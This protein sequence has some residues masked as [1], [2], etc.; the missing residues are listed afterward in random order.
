MFVGLRIGGHR[1]DVWT[2]HGP[3]THLL[4]AAGYLGRRSLVLAKRFPQSFERDIEARARLETRPFSLPVT[5]EVDDRTGGR[6]NQYVHTI[7]VVMLD[8]G[9]DVPI[10][11]AHDL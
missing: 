8:A 1:F 9:T 10:T 2:D 11:E 7:D 4:S 3:T 6:C 5:E